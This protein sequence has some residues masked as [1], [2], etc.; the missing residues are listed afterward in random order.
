MNGVWVVY[1]GLWAVLKRF[2]G[3]P[4]AVGY[5]GLVYSALLSCDSRAI[6]ISMMQYKKDCSS[7]C[8]APIMI[9]LFDA[10]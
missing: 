8:C 3:H 2:Y 6:L 7:L 9:S 5:A 10:S 1:E 4:N